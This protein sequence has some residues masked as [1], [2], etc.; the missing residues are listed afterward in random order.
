MPTA[1]PAEIA[2]IV[3]DSAL[4]DV[5][6]RSA[7]RT[8]AFETDRKYFLKIAEGGT[9]ARQAKMTA[10][11]HEHGLSASVC[12][13]VTSDR[14][15]LIT[16][17]IGGKDGTSGCFIAEPKRLCEVYARSLRMLHDMKFP[18]DSP[19]STFLDA[20]VNTAAKVGCTDF[21]YTECVGITSY[22]QALD[23]LGHAEKLKYDTMLHGD[24]CLPNIL[25]GDDFTLRGFIDL[26]EAGLGDRHFDIFWAI[27][28]L[29]YNLGTYDYGKY[30][31]DCYGRDLVDYDLVR[32]CAAREYFYEA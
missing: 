17:D 26:G 19:R 22:E 29:G 21:V 5:S 12:A 3:S 32:A 2:A 14:D 9:L 10:L 4:T 27:W 28:S 8:Y 30:F 11:F 31:I 16:T 20:A 23:A 25:L 24:Y 6:G 1:F 7:A 15:Y 13:Y 18:S